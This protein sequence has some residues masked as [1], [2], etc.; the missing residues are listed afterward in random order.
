MAWDWIRF[1]FP[2]HYVP[3]SDSVIIDN[4]RSGMANSRA[5][6]RKSDRVEPYHLVNLNRVRL[7]LPTM[8]FGMLP[9]QIVI[10]G[11]HIGACQPD[12]RPALPSVSSGA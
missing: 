10:Q 6:K 3:D 7:Y 1:G 12:V 4:R 9:I 5:A 8:I 11:E 2:P